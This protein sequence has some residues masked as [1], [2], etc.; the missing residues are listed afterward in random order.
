MLPLFGIYKSVWLQTT[1]IPANKIL[2]LYILKVALTVLDAW[3]GACMVLGGSWEVSIAI[4]YK[5]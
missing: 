1:S 5:Y 4:N 2:V 3:S